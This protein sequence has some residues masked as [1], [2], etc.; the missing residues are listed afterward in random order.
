MDGGDGCGLYDRTE[1]CS[2]KLGVVGG[3]VLGLKASASAGGKKKGSGGSGGLDVAEA[4]VV[5]V[6][7][8][9]GGGR[10]SCR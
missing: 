9:G 10:R 3:S 5:R 6:G 7:G 4:G 2:Y 8:G 1:S